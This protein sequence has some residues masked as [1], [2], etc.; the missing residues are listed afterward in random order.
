M[1]FCHLTPESLSEE[2]EHPTHLNGAIEWNT[3]I[4]H[5][6]WA[7]NKTAGGSG[8]NGDE[9]YWKNPQFLIKL[10]DVDFNDHENM[11]TLI[12]ALMQKFTREKRR[13]R[14]GQPSEEFIQFRLYKVN[15]SDA[16]EAIAKSAKLT[17][18][19][20][21]RVG[22]SGSYVNKREVTKRFRIEPGYYLVI[23]S[24]FDYNVEGQ[25]LL[26]FFTET[27]SF[28]DIIMN[29]CVHL[30]KNEPSLER[31]DFSKVKFR[32]N[33]GSSSRSEGMSAKSQEFDTNE[34]DNIKKEE[35]TFCKKNDQKRIFA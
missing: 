10:V 3:I 16:E 1:Q 20:T 22:N 8:N 9:R 18:D 35:F 27:S 30:L 4:A 24:T 34:L 28:S 2:I 26:R 6:E 23:P 19:Q 33:I 29:N 15:D 7:A 11:S 14:S 13:E 12:I 25:F 21:Q 31:G 17:E 5:G 32:G